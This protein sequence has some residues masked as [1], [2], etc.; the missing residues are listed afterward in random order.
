MFCEIEIPFRKVKT[1]S[2][3]L[4]PRVWCSYSSPYEAC[5]LSRMLLGA[6][7]TQADQIVSTLKEA[8]ITRARAQSCGGRAAVLSP[9]VKYLQGT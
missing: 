1:V 4:L 3:L 8:A 6:V 7:T 2:V 9:S 5:S